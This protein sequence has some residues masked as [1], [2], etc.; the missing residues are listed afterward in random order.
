MSR[1][2]QVRFLGDKGGATRLR[3]PTETVRNIDEL[4]KEI[5]PPSD[6][7][8]RNGFGNE[9][10]ILSLSETEKTEVEKRL[11]EMLEKKDDTLIGE[12]LAIMKSENSLQA[13]K[14]RLELTKNSSPKIMW[15]SFINE[16]KGGDEEMKNIALNEFE[17]VTEKY[18]QIQAFHYLS[19]FRD[20]R[21]NEKIQSYTNHKDYLIAY[22]ARTSIG[23]ETK[24]LI[25]RERT[26]NKV[27]KWW[28]FW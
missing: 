20:V 15:A 13:L 14:R 8:H 26:R 22:N 11:I 2:V 3:Y 10:I 18:T 16:I 21:I 23:I 1:K 19:R 24:D 12:T 27:K 4:L 7:H 9:G 6:Y 17:N 25:E 28:Q 5:I